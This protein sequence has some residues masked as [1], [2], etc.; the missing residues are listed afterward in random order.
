MRLWCGWAHTLRTC[1]ERRLDCVPTDSD[2][3]DH[4]IDGGIKSLESVPRPSGVDHRQMS[5]IGWMAK[6]IIDE[7][8]IHYITKTYCFDSKQEQYC[9]PVLSPECVMILGIRR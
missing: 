4:A 9:N 1:E 3:A 2:V 6:R 5:E 8:R 7:G